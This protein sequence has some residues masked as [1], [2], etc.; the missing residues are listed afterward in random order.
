MVFTAKESALRKKIGDR[1]FSRFE[2]VKRITRSMN[3]AP[4]CEL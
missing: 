2:R 4:I 3:E 1:R